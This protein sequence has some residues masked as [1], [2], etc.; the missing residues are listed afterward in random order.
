MHAVHIYMLQMHAVH[1]YVRMCA[2]FTVDLD[3]PRAINTQGASICVCVFHNNACAV[4]I[5]MFGLQCFQ[6]CHTHGYLTFIHDMH[7]VI[8][9]YM[10]YRHS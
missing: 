3:G 4:L 9:V 2:E 10:M 6:C 7:I 1:I 5:A 8:L